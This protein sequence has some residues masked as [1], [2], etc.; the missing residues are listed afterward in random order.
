MHCSKAK[1]FAFVKTWRI[2]RITREK[3]R[4]KREKASD[5]KGKKIKRTEKD[6][7]TLRVLASDKLLRSRIVMRG[8]N[9]EKNAHLHKFGFRC[10]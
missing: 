3:K 6:K 7:L 2:A 8:F 1:E 10:K 9:R 4:K 5:G